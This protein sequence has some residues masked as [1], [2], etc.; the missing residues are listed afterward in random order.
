MHQRFNFSR[1]TLNVRFE[2]A[3]WNGRIGTFG[4]LAVLTGT[5]WWST[6]VR[7]HAMGS[8]TQGLV[9]VGRAMPFASGVGAFTTMWVIMMAAMMFPTI[10][11]TV[12]SHR[13]Q[14]RERGE[15]AFATVSFV[16]GYMA[17]WTL[18]GFVPLA[19]LLATRVLGHF[20]SWLSGF[21]GSMLAIA[22]LYQ[23]TSWKNSCLL[24]C[25]QPQSILKAR[26]LGRGVL[27]HGRLGASQ[28]LH[29]LGC[30]WA[31][32]SVLLVVGLMNTEWMAG[33]AV[34]FKRLRPSFLRKM[35]TW[36]G[37]RLRPVSSSIRLAA[38]GIV[39]AGCCW[40]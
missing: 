37:L 38:W 3:W 24:T 39:V 14:A 8:M 29:C 36:V 32:M 34:V 7:A 30:C 9:Q 33:I 13:L 4:A 19:T 20:D 17:I 40:K 25:R 6:L 28:G 35:L 2:S 11:Q 22:G 1:G 26:N 18:T 23:F 10:S 21:E 12:L 31:L 15:G 16:A 27:G 5:A